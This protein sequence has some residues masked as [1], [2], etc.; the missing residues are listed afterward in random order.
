MGSEKLLWLTNPIQKNCRDPCSAQTLGV[1]RTIRSELGL[2]FYTLEVDRIDERFGPLLV[3]VFDKIRAREDTDN[4]ESDKE[5]VID[6]G[7]IYLGRYHP[8]S[9]G[10]EIRL[11]SNNGRAQMAKALG[12]RQPGMLETLTWRAR[13]I[14]ESIPEAHIEIEVRS[15]GLNFHDVVYAMG[16]ISS[17]RSPVPLGM[18]VS[19]TVRRLGSGVTGLAVGDRVMSFT[20]KDGFSTHLVVADHCVLKIP[21]SM[22]FEEAATIQCCYTTAVHAL[23]DA[24]KLRKGMS[25]LIHSA[26]GGVGLA[27][28]QVTKMMGGEV[29]ATVSSERKV[30]HLVANYNIARERIFSSRDPSFLEGVMQQ[31]AGKGVDLVL[32]SLPGEMLH[33][34][35]RCVAKNG[36]LLELGQRDLAGYGQLDLSRFLSNR[37]YCGI[38]VW[39][40]FRDQPLIIRE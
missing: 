21:D 18:E 20:H 3:S 22:S 5:F 10:D 16:L 6:N 27:A 35:W 39:D 25:V 37:S 15:A 11:K 31:T 40:L 14:P 1:A 12:V 19:G 28:I 23:L 9:L 24:G 17:A 4:L 29:F 32:N 2:H 30:Q 8:F 33:A 36:T 26:C 13:P 34:S 7:V 38:N